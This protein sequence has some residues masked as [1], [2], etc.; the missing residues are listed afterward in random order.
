MIKLKVIIPIIII[1]I[2]VGLLIT[3]IS[4]EENS[5]NAT[6]DASRWVKSGSFEIDKS[7][8]NIGEKIFLSTT[9]LLPEDKGVVQFLRP[10][11]NTHH[12]S[13]IKIPFDGME[14]TKFNYYFEPRYNKNT[15]VCSIDD[16]AGNWI[17][18]F[19]GTQYE[20]INFE[21]LAQPSSWDERT[22]EP[23]C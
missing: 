10:I 17:V 23:I 9:N 13:Y 20:D 19:S 11:N 15:G 14:K 12:E 7:Q 6:N 5:S 16:I 2:I 22:F 4:N 3:F 21:I 8:Y 18:K 1:I